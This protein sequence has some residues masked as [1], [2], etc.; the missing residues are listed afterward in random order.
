MRCPGCDAR[1]PA[2]ASWCSQCLAPLTSPAKP[3]PP[4]PAG[5]GDPDLD[6]LGTSVAASD[7]DVEELGTAVDAAGTPVSRTD[8]P[9]DVRVRDGEVE[10]RCG[11]CGTWQPLGA[12]RCGACDTPRSGF[13]ERAPAASGASV[14]PGTALAASVVLPGSGHVMLGAAGAGLARALLWSLWGVGGWALLRDVAAR[15]AGATLLAGALALWVL[16]VVDT[17]RRLG[18]QPDLLGARGLALL[19]GLVTGGLVLSVVVTTLRA[20]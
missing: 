19:V 8:A 15:W 12:V 5:A 11:T 14:R 2:T 16:S 17:R 1:N 7:T 13:G 18:G 3:A 10:W 4:G 6:G 20:A 9:R